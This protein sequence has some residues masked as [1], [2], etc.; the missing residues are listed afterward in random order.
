MCQHFKKMRLV[1]TL[2]MKKTDQLEMKKNKKIQAEKKR[3]DS[4]LDRFDANVS[5]VGNEANLGPKNG[6]ATKNAKSSP[7]FLRAWNY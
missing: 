2:A 5:E 6:A 7:Q 3:L 1:S 4:R